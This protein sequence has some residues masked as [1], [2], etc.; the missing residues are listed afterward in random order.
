[1]DQN[2]E[3]PMNTV[4]EISIRIWCSV[5]NSVRKFVFIRD[6]GNDEVYK[7]GGC[8]CYHRVAVR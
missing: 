2:K 4:K 1:M 6:E 5:C 7:C 3:N 8:N